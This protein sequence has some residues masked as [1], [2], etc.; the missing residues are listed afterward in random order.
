MRTAIKDFAL[1]NRIYA[2]ATVTFYT[3]SGGAK[4]ATKAPL[5]VGPT[6][7]S[8][9]G[10]PQVLGSD[11]KLRRAVYVEVPTIATISGL[12]IP[13][14]DT[15]IINPAPS[16]RINSSTQ[17]VEYSVDGDASWTATTEYFFRQRGDWATS[18]VYARNDL[19]IQDGNHYIA[20]T[21]HT[22]GTFAT[23]LGATKWRKL[24]PSN[25]TAWMAVT[26]QPNIPWIVNA[27][28]FGQVSANGGI[29]LGGAA[30]TS[31]SGVSASAAAIGVAGFAWNDN[32][33]T[34]KGAWGAYFEGKR[35]SGAGWVAAVEL[36]GTNNGSF[37]DANPYTA[38]GGASE[39][40]FGAWV[41]SGGDATINPTAAD[42][43]AALAITNNGAKWGHGLLFMATSLRS[44]SGTDGTYATQRAMTMAQNHGIVWMNPDNNRA[45]HISSL[46]GTGQKSLGMAFISTAVRFVDDADIVQAQIYKT[47]SANSYLSLTGNA[48]AAPELAASSD[49]ASNVDI[50]LTPKGTGKTRTQ[51]YF[52]NDKGFAFSPHL[53]QTADYTVTDSDTVITCNKAGTLTLTLPTPSSYPGRV[54]VVRTITANTV[55]SASFNVVPLAGGAAG[56]AILA[57][58]AGKSALLMSDGT[59]WQNILAN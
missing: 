13:D 12:T 8:T 1:A 9:L 6:G 51:G 58:T 45:A 41:A 18:T 49:S 36:D 54:L 17:A 15:G 7:S 29:G 31:D 33:T 48:S 11:G 5:Y 32:T 44:R 14:H 55:V 26:P 3:V 27:A 16:F 46:C 4:T 53:A 35:V 52:K 47:A 24:I 28:S 42:A 43:T 10:N 57:A 25:D 40:T 50:T 21:G 39:M 59:N 38:I 20:V 34:K 37:L 2:G 30:R 22:A 19:V 23:D 56:T